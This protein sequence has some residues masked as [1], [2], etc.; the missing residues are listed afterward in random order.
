MPPFPRFVL[1]A[2]IVFWL[3]GATM[4]ALEGTP[5]GDVSWP[6]VIILVWVALASIGSIRGVRWGNA[7]MTTS[8]VVVAI[9]LCL[10]AV[11]DIDQRAEDLSRFQLML[12]GLPVWVGIVIITVASFVVLVPPVIFGWRKSWYRSSW[13]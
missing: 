8:H 5:D 10:G 11:P 7:M 4:I 6:S 13:W 12:V 2:T 3:C 1:L 9:V